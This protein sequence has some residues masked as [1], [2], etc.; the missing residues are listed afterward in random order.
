MTGALPRM[1]QEFSDQFNA[2]YS[3]NHRIDRYA[4][5]KGDPIA[6]AFELESTACIYSGLFRMSDLISLQPN[7]DI[8]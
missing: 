6:S 5:A 1:I 2:G 4:M 8:I 3:E 7:L